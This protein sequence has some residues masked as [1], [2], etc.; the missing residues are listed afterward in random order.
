MKKIFLSIV[1]LFVL[2]SCMKNNQIVKQKTHIKIGMVN[3]TP[4]V[5]LSE[6]YAVALERNGFDVERVMYNSGDELFN[7]MK[8]GKINMFIYFSNN[9]NSFR[10]MEVVQ[11]SKIN[12]LMNQFHY[13]KL[14]PTKAFN[15]FSFVT[16]KAFS[17][18]YKVT[19]LSQIKKNS[20]FITYG[21]IN[22]FS[23][24]EKEL[25]EK[26]GLFNWKNKDDLNYSDRVKSLGNKSVDLIVG[27]TLDPA[28]SSNKYLVLKDDKGKIEKCSFV[29]IVSENLFKK[30]EISYCINTVS[31]KTSTKVLQKMLRSH[32]YSS[33]KIDDLAI[34]FN[35]KYI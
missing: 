29:P 3:E 34:D 18:K 19:K 17:T 6:I 8:D 24:E 35:N 11:S 13:K 25:F 7:D 30:K 23:D 9:N 14:K 20:E 28:F 27:T 1:C 16:R 10:D 4:I 12:T 33:K 5:L 15:S 32:Y 26:Y 21:S 22:E 31:K 2:T